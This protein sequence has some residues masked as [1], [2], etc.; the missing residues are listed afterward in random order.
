MVH[1]DISVVAKHPARIP[2]TSPA[3]LENKS[4]NPDPSGKLAAASTLDI[5]LESLTRQAVEILKARFSKI[6]TLEPGG[7]FSCRAVYPAGL[8]PRWRLEGR[9]E[10]LLAQALYRQAVQ[11]ADVVFIQGKDIADENQRRALKIN[12]RDQLCLLPLNGSSEVNGLLVLCGLEVCTREQ[13]RLAALIADQASGCIYRASLAGQLAESQLATV[14]AL[15]KTLEARDAYTGDHSKKMSDWAECTAIRL[16]LGL[17][18]IQAV[19]WAALL[20]DIGKIGI[21][22]HILNRPGPLT[23]EEW[24]IMRR[25]PAIGAE[26][27][28]I[29][30][31]LAQ[32]ARL[33]R[34]HHEKFDGNGYPDGLRG[35]DIPL[36]ARILAVVDSYSAMVDG[37]VYHS[38]RS[39]QEAIAE[40][41]RWSGIY[42]D[43]QVVKAFMSLFE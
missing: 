8:A 25:H 41:Q 12:L 9:P 20:H 26:I 32:V 16:G 21:P 5:M 1:G 30:V 24:T 28:L 40:L 34:S 13:L 31:N 15:A 38:A 3:W 18:E 11:A 33:I 43:P 14:L 2:T 6:V 23:P 37:R 36:G 19:N 35:A 10:P 7:G 22:D 4:S 42:Y 17:E 39:H 29:A 27:V